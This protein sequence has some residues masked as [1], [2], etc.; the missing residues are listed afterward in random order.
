MMLDSHA[1]MMLS[2]EGNIGAGKSTFL[3]IVAQN[4][5]VQPI[6]EPHTKWQS[7]GNE[8][9]LEKFYKDPRRWAYTFQTYAFVTRV[10]EQ[11]WHM[12]TNPHA[13]YVLERSVYS[14]R[15]CFAKN[16]FD[17]GIMSNLEW[18]LYQ[19]WFSWLVDSYTI[20]PSGFIYL[21]AD[22]K[23]CY[24]RLVKRNRNEEKGVSLEYLTMLHDK[25]EQWLVQKFDIPGTMQE[26]PVLILDCNQDFESDAT[27]QKLLCD[28]ITEF[29]KLSN[30]IHKHEYFESS[31]RSLS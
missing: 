12:R 29:F 26:V 5:P 28:R 14:D 16:A 15:Y 24:E 10:M 1:S 4:L 7:I 19:E 8:N 6:F 25:H 18:T 23:V 20:K 21:R 30:Q 11:E 13:T 22:P 9:L 27:Q 31:S 3:K 2:I 17:M